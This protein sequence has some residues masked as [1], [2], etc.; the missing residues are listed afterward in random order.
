MF[1]KLLH[2]INNEFSKKNNINKSIKSFLLNINNEYEKKKL[3]NDD[4]EIKFILSFIN[5]YPRGC[6]ISKLI[7]YLMIEEA[8]N[9]ALYFLTINHYDEK[10]KEKNKRINYLEQQINKLEDKL[11]E[12][13][14][15]L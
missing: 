6:V 11:N 4:E 2:I 14:L 12:F 10:I 1:N 7:A 5:Q 15:T 9:K 13:E 8:H 3:Y